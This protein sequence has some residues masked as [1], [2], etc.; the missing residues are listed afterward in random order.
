MDIKEFKDHHRRIF[1]LQRYLLYGFS[2]NNKLM[3]L[4]VDRIKQIVTQLRILDTS[5]ELIAATK[6]SKISIHIITECV[7]KIEK[8]IKE[9]LLRNFPDF[10]LWLMNGDQPVGICNIKANDIVWSQNR[11]KRGSI[12]NKYIYMSIKVNFHFILFFLN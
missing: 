12:C 9:P 2:R 8:L 4:D 3:P 7:I 5:L 1:C 6:S 10:H 11:H